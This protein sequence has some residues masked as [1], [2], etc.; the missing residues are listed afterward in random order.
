MKA[1][2]KHLTRRQ[3]IVAGLSILGLLSALAAGCLYFL[4]RVENYNLPPAERLRFEKLKPGS[5]VEV[6]NSDGRVVDYWY[7]QRLRLYRP[8]SQID[9]KLTEFVVFL[10]DAKFFFHEG[11]DV[12]EI[13]NSIEENLEKG[14]IKRGASTIT[15]Q[16]AK[17]L[18]LDKERSFTRKL[19]EMPWTYR[20][21]SDLSKKQIL[22]L[23][24]NV[25]EWGPGVYGAEAAARHFFDRSAAQLEIGQAMYLALIIPNPP[26]FDL[27][28]HPKMAEYLSKKK[29][30][31]VERLVD[32][33]KIDPGEK[34]VYLGA[35]FGLVPPEAPD[36]N[37]AVA[38]EGTYYGNRARRANELKNFEKRE[39][40]RRRG[41]TS[42]VF[43]DTP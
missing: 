11:F 18:F 43:E 22:E 16:L 14:R 34:P 27:F 35:D 20:L 13:K 32:E 28:A 5:A 19:F 17:N 31:L 24:M 30:A 6:R 21:E 41:A 29:A 23:Y 4:Q 39:R 25:I 3:R 9:P 12:A 10:E 15:Q 8:L 40:S 42:V 37:Y 33:K 7:E 2:L 38:H 26:R 36:R 1:R